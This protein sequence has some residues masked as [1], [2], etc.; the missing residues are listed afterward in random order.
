MKVSKVKGHLS[1]EEIEERIKETK[2]F[3]RVRRWLVIRHALV[4]PSPA[5]EIAKRIGISVHMVHYLIE[6]YNRFGTQAMDTPGKGRRQRAYMS[7]KEEEE[8]LK[9]FIKKGERGE[10]ATVQVIH[11]ALM[12]HLGHSVHISTTYRML[13]RHGWRKIIPRPQHVKAK[14][15]IQEDFKKYFPKK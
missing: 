4:D 8:F 7:F 11:E 12:S 3:W 10:I 14:E 15:E 2:E 13:K 6:N 5:A 1:L 9:V